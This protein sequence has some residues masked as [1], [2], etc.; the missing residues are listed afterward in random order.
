M[1]TTMKKNG[2]VML[3]LCLV[4]MF[5]CRVTTDIIIPDNNGDDINWNEIDIPVPGGIQR[6]NDY[7]GRRLTIDPDTEYQKIDGFGAA[8]AWTMAYMGAFWNEPVKQQ[9]ADW[10]FNQ[11]P[12]NNG[13]PTGIGLSLWRVN[14]GAGSFEQGVA[15]KLV[16][17]R[18]GITQLEDG[19]G[20]V[21]PFT[22]RSESYLADINDPFNATVN[23]LIGGPLAVVTTNATTNIWASPVSGIVYDWGKCLGHQYWMREAKKRGVEKL[24]AIAFSPVIPW[25]R[26]GT[27]NNMQIGGQWNPGNWTYPMLDHHGNLSEEG[28]TEYAEYI[29][30]ILDHFAGQTVTGPDGL[31]HRL[32]FDY[33]SP[34]NETQFDNS[35]DGGEGSAWS[36]QNVMRLSRSL[37]AA[38]DN[39]S[40]TN[41]A[42][43]PA[44]LK[45]KIA[46]AEAGDFTSLYADV[47][48]STD[49]IEAFFNPARTDTYM[50]DILPPLITGHTYWTHE[51][52]VSMIQHRQALRNKTRQWGIEAWNTEWCGLGFGEDYPWGQ[53]A[54]APPWYVALFMAKL[55]HTDMAVAE[56]TSWQYWTAVDYESGMKNQ[57]TLVGASPGTQIYDPLMF[58]RPGH[59][60]D[61]SGSVKAQSTMWTLGNYSLFVR[62]GFTRID[63]TP[64]NFSNYNENDPQS[65]NHPRGL[66]V[67]AYKSPAG[68]TDYTG[69][70][71]NR[72]VVVYV[73]WLDAPRPIAVDFA[74]DRLPKLMRLY[75][76]TEGNSNNHP[77]GRDEGK[78]GMRRMA[79][80]DGVYT[81]PAKSVLTVVYDF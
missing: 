56:L 5:G 35:N 74:D 12:D 55:I 18:P 40:R 13:Q 64:H 80:E 67:T 39:P 43:L 72:I 24:M 65:L 31:P 29:A 6:P 21:W 42:A 77:D 58:D 26:S 51:T 44:D 17:Y 14:L 79:H 28:Y 41:L 62:P 45:P 76:T 60:M 9:V 68:F 48:R 49:L 78:M 71:L 3:G 11:G 1:K 34:V 57:Y 33:M 70:P 4:L 23:P 75:V 32:S 69:N 2:L 52:D 10:L 66:M 22:R 50:A 47:G 25:T 30:D 46:V 38:F 63:V 16:S 73:N 53:H 8:D 54:D 7:M 61:N 81:I 59:F 27:A 36:N 15:S 19:G 20:F 37:R